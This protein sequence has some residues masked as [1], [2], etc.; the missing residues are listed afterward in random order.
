[1]PNTGGK[2]KRDNGAEDRTRTGTDCSTRP[3]TVRVYQIPPLRQ[4]GDSTTYAKYSKR[5]QTGHSFDPVANLFPSR[6]A[7]GRIT[8]RHPPPL[9]APGFGIM[10]AC[11]IAFSRKRD[12]PRGE[13]FPFDHRIIWTISSIGSIA[14]FTDKWSGWRNEDTSSPIR[15]HSCRALERFS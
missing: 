9:P 10:S 14:D 7:G 1:M 11:S 3:S 12:S 5:R 4:R 15:R 8:P 6:P 2:V 13:S